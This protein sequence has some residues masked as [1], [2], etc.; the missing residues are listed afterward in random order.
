VTGWGRPCFSAGDRDVCEI[1]STSRSTG[2]HAFGPE[3]VSTTA[4]V[5]LNDVYQ[6]FTCVSHTIQALRPIA[7]VLAIR[8]RLA[9]CSRGCVVPRASHRRIAPAARPGRFLPAE[10]QVRT[11]A[12]QPDNQLRRLIRS[13]RAQ[14]LLPEGCV[15]L[16][17][18]DEPDNFR[19]LLAI[20]VRRDTPASR[21]D[22]LDGVFGSCRGPF[23]R[24]QASKTLLT[25]VHRR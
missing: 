4:L 3:R 2:T 23:G 8:A 5:M 9:A 12:Q 10:R 14:A 13:N 19:P 7:F 16:R 22:G 11:V 21:Q 1:E 18:L 25:G 17:I 15:K 6:Q 24:E 20:R